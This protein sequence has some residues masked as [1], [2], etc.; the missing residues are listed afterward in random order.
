MTSTISFMSNSR[1]AVLLSN[2]S[3]P[4]PRRHATIYCVG[5][6][7]S[8]IEDTPTSTRVARQRPELSYPCSDNH[9][10]KQPHQADVGASLGILNGGQSGDGLTAAPSLLGPSVGD[11]SSGPTDGFHE[12]LAK[13]PAT[14]SKPPPTSA[15]VLHFAGTGC[16]GK[17]GGQVVYS[18][19]P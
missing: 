2:M 9:I 8:S 18:T 13:V 7:H 5:L 14:T 12:E 16:V 6:M 3:P 11:V 10:P 1:Y 19:L 17:T 15:F 4:T